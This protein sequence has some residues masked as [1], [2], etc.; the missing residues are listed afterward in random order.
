MSLNTGNQLHTDRSEIK[1]AADFMTILK[2][3]NI[4]S[5]YFI[6]GK[7]FE[8]EWPDLMPICSDD[9]IEIGGH[10]YNCFVPELWHR[11]WNKLTGNYNGPRWQQN[12]D[13]Q[14]TKNLIFQKT[15]KMITSWRNHMYMHG[16]NTEALLIN[17]GID[18]CCDGVKR[19][20]HGFEVHPTGLLNFPLNI[21]PDHEH[22]YHA[23][24][25]PEWVDQWIKR[26][27]WSDDYGSQS[28]YIEDWLN[29]VQNEITLRESRGVISHLIIHPITLYLCDRYQ[30][31]TTLAEF[32]SQYETI[33]VS[34][35][36]NQYHQSLSPFSPR[37]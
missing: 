8:Q 35:L 7:S 3:Y 18:V 16:P 15:G 4:K 26:Y 36:S 1:I 2:R 14:K 21:I 27:N 13:I 24:R 30:S 9:N 20:S 25:T 37:H 31:M 34:E 6:T 32:I 19:V 23:E 5:T 29:I 22:L 17:N 12:W 11:G 33:Q 28:Y 10:N